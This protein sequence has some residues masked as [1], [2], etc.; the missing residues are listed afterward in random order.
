MFS[1]RLTHGETHPLNIAR[2][3]EGNGYEK[4]YGRTEHLTSHNQILQLVI[5]Q[6]EKE[7][8]RRRGRHSRSKDR[9]PLQP[10]MQLPLNCKKG[11]K[12]CPRMVND[13]RKKAMVSLSHGEQRDREIKRCQLWHWSFRRGRMEDRQRW[14]TDNGHI[15]VRYTSSQLTRFVRV[16]G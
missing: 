7:T 3:R 15:Q 8:H 12:K 9:A 13:K 4:S 2:E 14:E 6:R 1:S 5:P 16:R 11:G 10:W